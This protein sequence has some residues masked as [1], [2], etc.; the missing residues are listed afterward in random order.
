MPSFR[1]RIE[2]RIHLLE[3]AVTRACECNDSLEK[4]LGEVLEREPGIARSLRTIAESKSE[5][6]SDLLNRRWHEMEG[7]TLTLTVEDYYQFWTNLHS[8][9]TI[10]LSK[11]TS[12]IPSGS[13]REPEMRLYVKRQ[14]LQM[15]GFAE[16]GFK[17]QANKAALECLTAVFRD[18]EEGPR[19]D[20]TR[21]K[22]S[23]AQLKAFFED[24]FERLFMLAAEQEV[25]LKELSAIISE[26]VAGGIAIRLLNAVISERATFERPQDF[27]IAIT[28][29]GFPV[30][31]FND[32][33]VRGN[34][35]GGVL[36]TAPRKI[37]S[38]VNCYLRLR[39]KSTKV[40][41]DADAKRVE[42]LLKRV[43][44]KRIDISDPEVYGNRCYRCLRK[45]EDAALQQRDEEIPAIQ[46]WYSIVQEETT[47][48]ERILAGG[49]FK[50]V[51]EVGC[52]SGRVI[53]RIFHL[54]DEKKINLP[55]QIVAY[56]QNEAIH[57]HYVERFSNRPGSVTFYKCLLGFEEPGKFAGIRDT[58][59]RSFDLIVAISNIV[60]WQSSE[61]EWLR[62]LIQQALAPNGTVFLTVYRRGKEL[63]RARMYRAAGDIIE[64]NGDD[65]EEVDIAIY[66]DAF[67]DRTKHKSRAYTR[68][69]LE[70]LLAEVTSDLDA[71]HEVFEVGE[72]MWGAV[73]RPARA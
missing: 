73:V 23:N 56:E 27:G 14:M 11:V 28:Q 67:V 5:N 61:A 49:N 4:R 34:P 68:D 46:T 37:A 22:P 30:G 70:E 41:Q 9:D 3:H 47:A 72:Y 58:D 24:P 54:A 69:Q 31:M 64:L 62:G 12:R 21:R 17:V 57:N 26:Q 10:A 50:K 19:W 29:E 35:Q 52:G 13:W 6:Y 60:G 1:R 18:L 71:K 7:G 8:R 16:P 25:D 63:E 42:Q 66:T 45:A 2:D 48:L 65:G 39:K 36:I 40:P 33:D 38:Y 55:S 32:V 59:T 44:E 20:V 15:E 53:D 51:L 43:L